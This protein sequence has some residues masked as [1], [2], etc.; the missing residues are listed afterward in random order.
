MTGAW[1]LYSNDNWSKINNPFDQFKHYKLYFNLENGDHL[2]FIDVRTFG[3][4]K[5]SDP[6]SIYELKSIAN[7]G[8][9]V[10]SKLNL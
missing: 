7:L 3:Q 2:L 9:D 5:V 6:N 1:H 8:P 10:R 4:F